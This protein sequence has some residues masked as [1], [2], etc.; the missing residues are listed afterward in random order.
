MEIEAANTSVEF[1][2]GKHANIKLGAHALLPPFFCNHFF[3]AIT[4]ENYKLW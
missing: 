4:L 2:K 3:L 1:I